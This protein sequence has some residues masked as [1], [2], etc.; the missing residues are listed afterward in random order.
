M[1]RFL[2]FS[3]LAILLMYC[4]SCNDTE[5][6]QGKRYYKAYCGNCHMEA[7]Q[8]L[9]KL[10]PTL[11]GAESITKYPEQLACM[12]RHGITPKDSTT[13]LSMPGNDQLS[14][15]HIT[16]IVNYISNSWGHEM[17]SRSYEQIKLD[18]KNCD[19]E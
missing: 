6:P 2:I 5:Y 16:N 3:F 13:L 11:A 1:I 18:L 17:G 7:G 15:I 19:T 9:N 8:G 4:S 10:I 14:D 12:I